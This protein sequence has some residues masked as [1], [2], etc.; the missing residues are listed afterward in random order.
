MPERGTE[1]TFELT[2]LQRLDALKYQ[3]V[4][5]MDIERPRDEVVLRDVLRGFLSDRYKDLPPSAIE[6]AVR[7]FSKPDGVD[8]LHRNLA[9]HQML[10]RGL[11]LKVEFPDG[12]I[13]HRHIYAVNW[14]ESHKNDIRAINQFPIHGQND[15]RP[16]VILFVNGLPLVVFELKNPYDEKPTVED[17]FNQ[18]QHYTYEI[19][20]LFDYNALVVISDGVTTLHGVWTAGREWYSP[21]KSIDG[22]EIEP[23]TTGSMK[24]LIEGLFPKDRLL[25]YIRDFIVFE[26]VNDKVT[27]KAARYH[28][29]FAVRLATEKVLETYNRVTRDRGNDS[30]S[31]PDRRIGVIWHTTGSGKSLSMVFL[32]GLLRRL[33]ELDNPL[34]LLEV[35]RNDLD[36]QL[37]DQ[38]IA[39][40]QLVGDV[41]QA[42][43]VDNLRDLL[44]TQGGGVILTTIEK[45]GL[46]ENENTHPILNTRPNVILI[47]DE[48]HRSQYGFTEGY[49]RYLADAVPNAMRL[50]FTGTPIRMS[51]ADTVEVFGDVIHTYDILQS[52]KDHATVPIYYEPRQIRLQL[53]KEDL[54]ALLAR[55]IQGRKPEEVNRNISRWA[56]LSAAA[57]TDDRLK[58]LAKD[59]LEHYLNRSATLKGKAMIVCMERLNCIRVYEALTALPDCPEVRIVMTGNLSEDPPEWSQK[60][61]LTT[62]SQR[63]SIKERMI[64]PDDPLKIVVVCDMWL[65]GTDIPC[66]HTL[67]VD[68]PMEGHNMIQAISR[69]NRVFS[70]KP[71]GLIVDYIGIGD[72]LREATNQY[73]KSGGHGEPA[74]DVET[75]GKKIFDQALQDIR[76]CLPSGRN[77]GGWRSMSDIDME[78]LYALVYGFLASNDTKRDDFI[79]AEAVLSSA[80]LLVKHLDD[81]RQ[82]ADE[83]IFH[84]RVRKQILK[85]T[86]G[87]RTVD[88]DRAVQDLVDDNI[89]TEG[90]IDIFKVAGIDK[91]DISILDDAFLQ[92]FKDHPLENLRVRLLERL[93]ADEIYRRQRTNL[94]RTKSFRQQLEKTLLDYHNRLIDAKEVIEQ[95]I[96]I[97]REWESDDQ[98]AQELGLT[99]EE[100]AFY[101][102]VAGNF[103]TIYDQPTLRDIVHEV[104]QTLKRNLKVDWTEPSREE[105][106]AG[107]KSAVKM[108]LRRKGVKEQDLEQ[109]LGSVM[110]QAQALYAEWPLGVDTNNG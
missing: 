35:D 84:Q 46:K 85:T 8:T 59:L 7:L 9:F 28:Q 11:E 19:P 42:Q 18:V 67:Y 16:D 100:I 38:F 5:G 94:A 51:G 1:S 86:S 30:V 60:G 17:A 87:G 37:S 106:R 23:N 78:D 81:C 55:I 33:P 50:G 62:K 25:A 3:H 21:W 97:R 79:Q 61:Y 2:T 88:L 39:A 109:F 34:F 95:M 56:A 108:V 47:A 36:N 89:H 53:T 24:T 70:D 43:S 63:E 93:M 92:T 57:R 71:H 80:F 15:R 45:F 110:I 83:I 10:T 48:A 66:L 72:S 31:K 68:K 101:D 4:F 82:F 32:V 6:Q 75:E 27:K 52:Q 14:D 64:D 74:P 98:R 90:V 65:T 26:T 73:T 99:P 107:V 103:M 13:E 29:F 58:D 91:P 49:A 69:V 40:R 22:F 41:R 102:A 76:A 44:Q 104:V 105:V 20:Q 12:R 54:D 96:A 77:Y